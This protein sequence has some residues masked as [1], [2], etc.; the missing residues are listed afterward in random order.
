MVRTLF[1]HASLLLEDRS[2]P[3]THIS[4]HG[5]KSDGF[6]FDTGRLTIADLLSKKLSNHETLL[7]LGERVKIVHT[8]L[9][10]WRLNSQD[11]CDSLD[12]ES[13]ESG[14]C[15]LTVVLLYPK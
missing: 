9:S 2:H 6:A 7:T 15:R 13:L 14:C 11:G 10:K 8:M 3:Q 4:I 1:F 12:G 5:E